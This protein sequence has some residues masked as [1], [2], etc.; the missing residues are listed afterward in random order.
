MSVFKGLWPDLASKLMNLF[1][2]NSHQTFKLV[3]HNYMQEKNILKTK[4]QPIFSY[5]YGSNDFD[6]I[7][8]VNRP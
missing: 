7:C 1:S 3:Y 5:K 2:P 8:V 6:K 4:N